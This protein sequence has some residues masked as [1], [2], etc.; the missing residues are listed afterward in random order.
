MNPLPDPLLLEAPLIPPQGLDA[1]CGKLGRKAGPSGSCAPCLLVKKGFCRTF[2]AAEAHAFQA[3]FSP[4]FAAVL[5]ARLP[6]SP[7]LASPIFALHIVERC[8][9]VH[10]GMGS[11]V[12]YELIPSFSLPPP[13]FSVPGTKRRCY[14]RTA[15]NGGGWRAQRVKPPPRAFA[16][17]VSR[18]LHPDSPTHPLWQVPCGSALLPSLPRVC[19]S[20]EADY[21]FS[22]S[23]LIAMSRIEYPACQPR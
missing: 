22:A 2:R 11:F 17:A 4:R 8:P 18:A 3:R 23:R 10:D 16:G 6:I 1:R 13:S 5:D 21:D 9:S 15:H 12:Q 19:G 14:R 7:P 20:P